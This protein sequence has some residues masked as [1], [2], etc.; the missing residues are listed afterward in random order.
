MDNDNVE[1]GGCK[2][3]IVGDGFTGRGIYRASM[4]L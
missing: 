2:V 1:C 4:D 3:A